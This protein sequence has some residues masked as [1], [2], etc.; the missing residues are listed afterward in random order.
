MNIVYDIKCIFLKFKQNL[1]VVR[2]AKILLVLL[3]VLLAFLI[4][5]DTF[6]LPHIVGD[7]SHYLGLAMK[8]DRQGFHEGYNLRGIRQGIINL[9]AAGEVKVVVMYLDKNPKAKGDILGILSLFGVTYFDQPFFHKPPGFSFMLMLSHKLF[10][11]KGQPYSAVVSN[12]GPYALIVRPGILMK[13]QFYAVIVPLFFGLGTVLITFFLGK[14]LFNYRVGLYSA[15]IYA[16]NPIAIL[17]DQRLL[18]DSMVAFF[19][20]LAVYLYTIAYEK[21]R[22]WFYVFSGLSCGAAVLAKQSGGFFLIGVFLFTVFSNRY[23]AWNIRAIPRIFVNRAYVLT[24]IGCFL[25]CGFWFL[26]IYRLFGNPLWQ[27][28]AAAG[29]DAGGPWADLLSKRPA[30]WVLYSVG[31]PAMAPPFILAYLSLKK[32]ALEG[33]KMIRKKAF[34]YRFVFLWIIIFIFAYMLR[35]GMEHRR[36]MPVYPLICIMA[37][38]Y[39][40]K[41]VK[42]T[43][44]FSKYFGNRYTREVLI[45]SFF[46]LSAVWMIAIAKRA[47]WTGSQIIAVPF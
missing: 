2:S 19:V 15:I 6:W 27:A 30:G 28:R 5:A 13:A 39:Y 33:W 3:V 22:D 47:V 36:M 41:F 11:E 25:V 35:S 31:I 1:I 37:C 26:K 14:R 24:V 10:A 12:L 17:M 38:Y 8:L 7:Q 20:T 4:R 32:F 40:D 21:D 42:Y 43:G 46:S 45:I 29:P 16:L 9:D 18:A 44:R 34:D 23:Q